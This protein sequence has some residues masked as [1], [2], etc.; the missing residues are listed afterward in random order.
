MQLSTIYNIYRLIQSWP[1]FLQ[2]LM[3]YACKMYRCIRYKCLTV[4]LHCSMFVMLSDISCSG[5]PATFSLKSASHVWV[6]P[7]R[8]GQTGHW[9][10]REV[11]QEKIIE[12]SL[13]HTSCCHT[14]SH[15][16][17]SDEFNWSSQ[18]IRDNSLKF[19]N[20]WSSIRSTAEVSLSTL[21]S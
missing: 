6:L 3:K 12:P 2:N 10:G 14:T 1:V 7:A 16:T 21:C 20:Y 19:Q 4:V 11:L 15:H 8:R 18:N 5:C 17:S 9:D 13:Y